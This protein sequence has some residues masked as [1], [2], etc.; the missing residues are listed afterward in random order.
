MI[1][2][3]RVGTEI[4]LMTGRIKKSFRNRKENL[5]TLQTNV[6]HRTRRAVRK[7]DYYV[8]ENAWTMMAVSAGLAFVAGFVL[9]RANQEAIAQAVGEE[10]SNSPE[11][12]RK[13]NSWEFL[14][15]AIPL[16]LFFWKTFQVSRGRKV[17]VEI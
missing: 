15:S 10:V 2:R 14:H 5:G 6:A 3:E 11:K 4:G 8:H 13:V 9:S 12:I 17:K 16:G 1:S 7:T